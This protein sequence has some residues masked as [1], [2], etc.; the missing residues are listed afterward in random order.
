VIVLMGL[1]AGKARARDVTLH[2]TVSQRSPRLGWRQA[3]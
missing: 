3:A 1:A 2:A